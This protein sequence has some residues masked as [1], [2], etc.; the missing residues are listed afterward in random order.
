MNS[1]ILAPRKK[2]GGGVTNYCN[3]LDSYLF[4]SHK[5]LFRGSPDEKESKVS[6]LIR[7]FADLMSFTKHAVRSDLIH[8]NTSLGRNGVL[9]D[10]PYI[11]ISKL[12]RKKVF[13]SIHG[14]DIKYANKI[15]SKKFCVFK[16]FFK[17]ADI[18]TVLFSNFRDIL[19]KW[20]FDPEKIKIESNAIDVTIPE[21][22]KPDN[23][24]ISILFLS[25]LF[26]EKGIFIT[27]EVFEKIN[28]KYPD[29]NLIVAGNGECL[30][31]A[32][33]YV[34]DKGISNVSFP[35]F[36][37]GISKDKILTDSHIYILPTYHQE[38]LPISILE[39][40]AY[41]L[42]VITRPVGGIKD[43]FI[44]EKMGYI[45]ES[46]DPIDYVNY[47]E[48]L[49]NNTIR[50]K[51]ISEYNYQYAKENFWPDKVIVRIEQLYNKILSAK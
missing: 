38:G 33:K 17:N 8:I 30:I 6:L 40:M 41:G 5:V 44:N 39:A 22:S 48:K 42:V 14:W 16:L 2:E 34:S 13:L 46:L 20:N 27:L 23:K 10:A 4:R 35:G 45:T 28:K 21:I 50:I 37:S 36:V 19:L 47:L 43:F 15:D 32:K 31:D 12:L 11:F 25:R 49:I 9:R 3:F 18:I 26:K 1:L 7:I 29:V 24:N 51:E